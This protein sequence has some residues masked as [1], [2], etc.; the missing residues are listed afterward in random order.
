M[1]CPQIQQRLADYSAGTLPEREHIVIA[2]HLAGC[3]AC[4]TALS[5]FLAVDQL[6]LD[7]RQQ[8][9]P[10]RVR[11]L[12]VTAQEVSLLRQWRRETFLPSVMQIIAL[13][14]AIPGLIIF[15]LPRLSSW[16][17][18]AMTWVNSHGAWP[19]ASTHDLL[20]VVLL[21]CSGV[22]GTGL[23]IWVTSR[24]AERYW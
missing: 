1:T 2:A 7:D 20:A 5:R 11:A 16:G 9:D 15:L 6:V 3:A 4:N 13:L 19:V 14:M 23:L 17:N 10:R 22:C 12:L 21:L 24:W 8:A 18:T